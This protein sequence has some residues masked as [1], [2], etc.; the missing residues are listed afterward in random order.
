MKNQSK[1]HQDQAKKSPLIVFE[2]VSRVI[3]II[4]LYIYIYIYIYIYMFIKYIYQI[5][6]TTENI[7]ICIYAKVWKSRHNNHKVINS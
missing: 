7:F 6:M 3:F 4:L 1:F 2:E 5:L